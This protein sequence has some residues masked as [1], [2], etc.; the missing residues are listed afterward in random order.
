[1]EDYSMRAAVLEQ[2]GLPVRVE[3]LEVAPPGPGE[4]AVRILASGICHSD[5]HVRDGEWE[6]PGPI[7]LGH[8][9]AG[10]VEAVGEGVREP[11]VGDQVVLSWY[12][13]CLRCGPCQQGRQ[14]LCT[15]S[16]SLEHLLP[17][18]TTR[19]RR[20]GGQP[21]RAYLALGTFAEQAV[22]PATAAVP[23]PARVP[24][25]VAALIGCAVSTGVGAVLK[26]AQVPAGA[27]VAVWGLGGVGLSVVMGAALVGASQIVAVDRAPE[28]LEH[29]RRVGA[30]DAVEAREP[31][32]TVEA[33]RRLTDGGPDFAFEAIGA[34]STVEQVISCLPRGGT[35]V[36][37]GLTPFGARASLD[38]F[39]FVDGS[40]RLLGSNYGFTVAAVD[41]PR[42]A[43]LYL[44][45]RLPI[46]ALI[47][48]TIELDAV[49]E[50]FAA[51]RR[52]DGRRRVI[53]HAHR[54]GV[55][56]VNGSDPLDDKRGD[57]G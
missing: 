2:P 1:V 22:V 36:L 41:F 29:A 13:P 26:T 15:G 5:L 53:L 43:G 50:A 18:G 27:R 56:V 11:K 16:R 44:A 4:V 9:G 28:K 21:V 47:E 14:W 12:Y 23:I 25:A 10:I 34:S 20:P 38:V 46:D 3:E 40:R 39:D 17:D 19:L 54:A 51:M 48:E 45:G 33:V 7:V 35:A 37:V 55:P 30:T 6:R 32:A 24:P 8:E 57:Q 42:Y 52:G 31:E 49:E